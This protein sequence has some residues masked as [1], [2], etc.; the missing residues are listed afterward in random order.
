M[1]RALVFSPEAV[2]QLAGLYAYIAAASTP[3]T[4]ARYIEAII[5]Y[6]ESLQDF[7]YRGMM[8]DDV[9]AGLRITHYRKRAVIA[10]DVDAARVSVIG[11]FYGGQNH[12]AILRDASGDPSECDEPERDIE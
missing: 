11:N 10:F 4:A 8:R 6:C 3:A 1:S 5:S 2:E 9:R 12:E 7:P